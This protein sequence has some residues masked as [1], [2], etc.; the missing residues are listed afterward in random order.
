MPHLPK[1]GL[2]LATQIF[3]WII[4]PRLPGSDQ[5][6]VYIRGLISI[7]DHVAM[8]S[9]QSGSVA[10]KISCQLKRLAKGRLE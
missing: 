4:K 10:A 7:A 3:R 8:E 9:L 2:T 5:E 6:I 1:A